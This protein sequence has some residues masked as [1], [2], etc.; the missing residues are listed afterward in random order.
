VF[1][2]HS[3]QKILKLK[4][5]ALEYVGAVANIF[6]PYYGNGRNIYKYSSDKDSVYSKNVFEHAC[7]CKLLVVENIFC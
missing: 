7:V 3:S 6:G 1:E 4:W 2:S 5:K